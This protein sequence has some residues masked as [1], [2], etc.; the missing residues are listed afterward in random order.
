MTLNATTKKLLNHPLATVLRRVRNTFCHY[1]DDDAG[2]S[3]ATSTVDTPVFSTPLARSPF[4][5]WLYVAGKTPPTSRRL[6]S[7]QADCSAK[8]IYCTTTP[9]F[10]PGKISTSVVSL[11]LTSI[12]DTSP[13]SKWPNL[14]LNPIDEL[15]P[16]ICP[17]YILLRLSLSRT[18]LSRPNRSSIRHQPRRAV[19]RRTHRG[20]PSSRDQSARLC[21]RADAQ[22]QQSP[23]G[24]RPRT[25]SDRRRLAHA[26]SGKEPRST[27]F[28]G[29]LPS[30]QD[31]LARRR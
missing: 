7:F 4:S 20:T 9:D 26:Q 14:S 10:F 12:P 16:L 15:P 29:P 2:M 11:T 30:H 17:R 8:V 25:L 22:F 21:A 24:F 23:R 1:S 31:G 6:T 19:T 18:R 13:L 5:Q 3:D 28:Q 27:E